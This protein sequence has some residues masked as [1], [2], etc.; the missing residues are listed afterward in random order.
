MH[1]R[2]RRQHSV[3]MD[4]RLCRSTHSVDSLCLSAP[5]LTSPASADSPRSCAQNTQRRPQNQ[6]MLLKNTSPHI[7]SI[8]EPR[9]SMPVRRPHRWQWHPDDDILQTTTREHIFERLPRTCTRDCVDSILWTRGC[10]EDCGSTHSVDSHSTPHTHTH[11]LS[12]S[13]LLACSAYEARVAPVP[14]RTRATLVSLVC[15]GVK[16][17]VGCPVPACPLS[18]L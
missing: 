12:L 9:E 16:R 6:S 15:V 4:S 3:T 17:S 5:S 14:L 1:H 11:S 13:C 18:T 7:C 8:Q 10:V 2:L